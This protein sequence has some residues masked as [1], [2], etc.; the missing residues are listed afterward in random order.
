MAIAITIFPNIIIIFLG[1]NIFNFS[2]TTLIM[3][4]GAALMILV[5]SYELF[6]YIHDED[7]VAH[8]TYMHLS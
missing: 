5:S 3:W 7:K 1:D 8:N 2:I 6:G 4:S